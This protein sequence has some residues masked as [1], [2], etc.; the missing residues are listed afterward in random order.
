[1]TGCVEKVSTEGNGKSEIV[2]FAAE[3]AEGSI[4]RIR[5]R[6]CFLRFL[7]SLKLTYSCLDQA[8]GRFKDHR[9]HR[10]VKKQDL[11]PLLFLCFSSLSESRQSDSGN[12]HGNVEHEKHNKHRNEPQDEGSYD[13]GPVVPDYG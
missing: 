4:Q 8:S 11:T 12:C 7:S 9:H 5:V 6:P 2:S 10:L 3:C 1:M 13:P